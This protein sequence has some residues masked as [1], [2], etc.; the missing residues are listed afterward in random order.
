M[1]F[2][3]WL[4]SGD[5]IVFTFINQQAS[6]PLLDSVLLPLRNAVTWIP[7]Y[8]FIL[9]WCIRYMRQYAMAF[10]LL[11]VCCF[12]LCDV[13]SAQL[14]KPLFARVRPCYE[15][16]MPGTVRSLVGCGGRYSF[17]SSHAANHFGL[18][19][20]WFWIIRLVTGKRWYWLWLWAFM[21]GYAQVYV[22]KH[23]PLDI[24]GGAF[25]G[26]LIGATF[27]KLF[28]RWFMARLQAAQ[29]TFFI[30]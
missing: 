2:L 28:E 25:L 19:A 21:I 16:D 11:T 26:Y 30:Q 18:A 1:S 12:V 24:A 17:P 10:I 14:F 6:S 29:K 23:Y 7:L 13:S 5:K 3:Q 9:Y 27:A 15:A 4:V 22:G 8:A 20:L